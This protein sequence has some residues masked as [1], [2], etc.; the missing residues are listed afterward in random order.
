M[1]I[2]QQLEENKNLLRNS[3]KKLAKQFK[4]TELEIIQIRKEIND[5]LGKVTKISRIQELAEESGL[6]LGDIKS[7]WLKEKNDKSVRFSLKFEGSK[8]EEE[9]KFK[10]EFQEFLKDYKP[11]KDIK[12]KYHNEF[13]GKGCLLLNKQDSHLDKFDIKGNNNIEERFEKLENKITAILGRAFSTRNLEKILYVVGSDEFNSEFTQMT[14]KGTPQQNI[15]TVENVFEQICNHEVRVINTLLEYSKDVNVIYISGNHDQFQGFYMISWLKAYFK[16]NKNITIDVSPE[17]R[18]YIKYGTTA[19]Q[20]N[21]GDVMKPKDLAAIFPMEFKT[22]WSSCNH[23]LSFVGDKHF[24]KQLDLQGISFFQIPAFSKAISSW[25][26]KHGYACKGE[27]TAF[28]IDSED[29]LCDTYK[30]LL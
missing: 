22:E 10:N 7:G 4:T 16:D 17:F 20:L 3:S 18:K 5:K 2:K 27:V 14:T 30:E 28:F 25:D 11:S 24:G 23:F 1:S 9:S 26:S 6:Q 29:G 12:C 8:S 19:I 15:G 13:K 21:H